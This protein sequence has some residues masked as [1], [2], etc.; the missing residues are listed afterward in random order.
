[1]EKG[2]IKPTYIRHKISNVITVTR[3]VTIHY[4]EFGKNFDFP[5]ETHDFW[6]MIYI[7][8]G[9]AEVLTKKEN[10]VLKQGDAVFLKPNQMHKICGNGI[11]SFNAFVI[12]FGT[13]S[14]GMDFFR[15]KI[16][17]IPQELKKYIALILEEGGNAFILPKNDPF[18]VEL[19]EKENAPV[20][21]LQMIRSYLEQLLVLLLR[22]EERNFSDIFFSKENMENHLVV[23]VKNILRDNLYGRV[24]VEEIC[25]TLHYS[26]TYLSKIFK[27]NCGFAI[28]SYYNE[29]KIKE[30]K[31]LIC[32]G[33]YNF[34]Q[35]SELLGFDNPHYFARVFKRITNMTPTE[36]RSSS[37]I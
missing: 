30:A 9:K 11:N 28:N 4:F 32:D 29:M 26:R 18:M 3:I 21:S 13:N 34:T 24:T 14:A 7:D 5:Y 25:N 16:L 12:S 23:S 33:K 2:Y 1:M 22:S 31:K 20:G 8:S 15:N 10:Y 19:K 37:A 35:I 36:Y 17:K 6:E 27:K